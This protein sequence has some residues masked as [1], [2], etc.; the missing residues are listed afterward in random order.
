MVK[1]A[2]GSQCYVQVVDSTGQ[3][4]VFYFPINGPVWQNI[5]IEMQGKDAGSYFGGAND[6]IIH[7]PVSEIDIGACK[8]T[9]TSGTMY[10][11]QVYAYTNTDVLDN[12]TTNQAPY[13]VTN[14]TEFPPGA[15]S[16][17]SWL[18]SGGVN[19]GG[20]LQIHS[21]PSRFSVHA[22]ALHSFPR[23]D[24]MGNLHKLLGEGYRGQQ[25]LCRLVDST[26]Q[27]LQYQFSFTSPNW[28]N[29]QIPLVAGRQMNSFMEQMMGFVHPPVTQICIGAAP[30][31]YY[32]AGDTTTESTRRHVH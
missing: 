12:F 23:A 2:S 14:G 18:P 13:S 4:H 1:D 5:Q 32:I 11:D 6:G 31:N 25:L 10:L 20:A 30:L 27:V 21:T 17:Y 3:D 19:S 15:T 22:V 8:R 16:T 7:T 28:Q 26:G 9:N 29:I 24:R